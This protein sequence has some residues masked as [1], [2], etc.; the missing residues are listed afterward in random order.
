MQ[1]TG[2]TAL[3]LACKRGHLDTVII[4]LERNA[5]TALRNRVCILLSYFLLNVHASLSLRPSMLQGDLH[6][7]L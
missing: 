4:L 2:F 3:M 6:G 1:E 5:N 7:L